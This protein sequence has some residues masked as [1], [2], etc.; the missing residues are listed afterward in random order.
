MY[1]KLN[2]K[3]FTFVRYEFVD[4]CIFFFLLDLLKLCSDSPISLLLQHL[5]NPGDIWLNSMVQVQG[6]YLLIFYSELYCFPSGTVCGDDDPD[7]AMALEDEILRE[8]IQ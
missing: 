3:P 4:L 6:L 5:C 1:N 7:P 2:L 8:G